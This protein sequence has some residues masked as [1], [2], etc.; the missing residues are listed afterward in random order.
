MIIIGSEFFFYEVH[1]I[2]PDLRKFIRSMM[3]IRG[4]KF[5]C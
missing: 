5:H 4:I 2:I 3:F 1:I